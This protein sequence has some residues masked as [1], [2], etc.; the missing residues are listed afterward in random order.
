MLDIKF[1]ACTVNTKFNLYPLSGLSCNVWPYRRTFTISL[2]H[3][4]FVHCS[5][6]KEHTKTDSL[7]YH[8]G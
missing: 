1:S 6:Y 7:C 8:C 5:Q 3:V 4:L 2:T